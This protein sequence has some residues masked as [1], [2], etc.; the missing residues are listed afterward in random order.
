MSF[1]GPRRSGKEKLTQQVD[2]NRG[3]VCFMRE[4]NLLASDFRGR[5]ILAAQW[6]EHS[7]SVTEVE[8]LNPAYDSDFQLSF[9]RL[10]GN[11]SII[12]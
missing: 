1:I 3:K 12:V 11:Q 4:N 5:E 6:V 7:T 9:H 8:G 10:S 2:I